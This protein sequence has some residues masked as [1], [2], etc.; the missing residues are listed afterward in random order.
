MHGKS[1]SQLRVSL[2]MGPHIIITC[3]TTEAVKAGTRFMYPKGW[4][5]ELT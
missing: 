4:K 5:A 1:I 3:N 2:T